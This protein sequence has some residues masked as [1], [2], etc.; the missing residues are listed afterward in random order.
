MQCKTRHSAQMENWIVFSTQAKSICREKQYMLHFEFTLR[1]N[2]ALLK[3]WVGCDM[4]RISLPETFCI[5]SIWEL[6][7]NAPHS[8]CLSLLF[9]FFFPISCF[10][11]SSSSFTACLYNFLMLFIHS[12]LPPLLSISPFYLS[13]IL[14]AARFSTFLV[15]MNCSPFTK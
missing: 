15:S 13:L 14:F 11:L 10:S 1:W 8:I 4:L 2:T 12:F 7:K 6:P 5:W 9:H 3:L